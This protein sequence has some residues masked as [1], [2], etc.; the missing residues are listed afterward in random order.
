MASPLKIAWEKTGVFCRMVKIEHSIFALPFA[1]L[2][3]FW[4]GE[5]WPGARPFW[6]LILAMV[7]VRSFAMAFNRLAD[8]AIDRRNPRTQDRPLVTGELTPGQTKVLLAV[9][10]AVFIGAC[11]G[12]NTLC[13]ALSVPAL[14]WAG[15]YSYTKRFTPLCHYFLGSVLALAPLA[16]WLAVNP[17][18][19]PMGPVLL[20]LGVMFW[21]AG[22]DI[23]YA[24]QDMTFDREQGL[25]SI[26]ARYGVRIAL[27]LSTFSH[28]NTVL[29][30]GLAGWAM[31]AG[32]VFWLG[33]GVVS[34]VILAE[35]RLISE[36]D[37]SR[38]NFAF[39]TM[40]G[41]V[42]L[43]FFLTSLLDLLGPDILP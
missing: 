19:L 33:W 25:Y 4:A 29:L 14:A 1:C 22:F 20:A 41:F 42:A 38:V 3:L 17:S 11:A 16:G 30:F 31:S 23:L 18:T 15:L 34:T 9:C 35:H 7:A 43:F 5:G 21:V 26:P 28:V 39:F 27:A 10:A 6:L 37:M 13:L 24:C 40:N 8:L 12:L 2:G 32:L 36:N